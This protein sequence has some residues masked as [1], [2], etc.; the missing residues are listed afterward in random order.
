MSFV[1]SSRS[2]RAL[3]RISPRFRRLDT[4][5]SGHPGTAHPTPIPH[6]ATE[7]S[8]KN[9]RYETLTRL[10]PVAT[11]FEMPRLHSLRYTLGGLCCNARRLERRLERPLLRKARRIRRRTRHAGIHLRKQDPPPW[12]ARART[13]GTHVDHMHS[14]PLSFFVLALEERLVDPCEPQLSSVIPDVEN[15]R[16]VPYGALCSATSRGN[17]GDG[18]QITRN[19]NRGFHNFTSTGATTMSRTVTGHTPKT[20]GNH[21]IEAIMHQRTPCAFGRRWALREHGVY[22]QRA[23]STRSVE[24]SRRRGSSRSSWGCPIGGRFDPLLVRDTAW[25]EGAMRGKQCHRW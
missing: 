19:G 6:T 4:R 20:L 18:Q 3:A 2:H 15:P 14:Y 1:T 5:L 25:S 7:Q 10:E 21:V 12:L 22:Q 11:T 8:P 13:W 9:R 24:R 16:G 17:R 23:T